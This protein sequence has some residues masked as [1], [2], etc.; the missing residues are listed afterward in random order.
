VAENGEE[1]I[2]RA[3]RERPDVILM[4]MMMPVMDGYDATRWMRLV[5]ARLPVPADGR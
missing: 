4:D 5:E 1:G 2:E 3:A